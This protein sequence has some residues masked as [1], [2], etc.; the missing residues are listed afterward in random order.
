MDDTAAP[1]LA[2]HDEADPVEGTDMPRGRRNA[3]TMVPVKDPS[4]YSQ[5]ELREFAK[6]GYDPFG[7][8]RFAHLS[9]AE[10][11]RLSRLG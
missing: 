6:A 5:Q 10:K 4:T 2:A 11:S 3:A 8:F 9:D 1:D 7:S